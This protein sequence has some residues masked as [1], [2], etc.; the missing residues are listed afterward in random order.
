MCNEERPDDAWWRCT[1]CGCDR[2]GYRDHCNICNLRKPSH[3]A[4]RPIENHSWYCLKCKKL[5]HPAHPFCTTCR[6][7]RPDS[8]WWMCSKCER[9]IEGIYHI[10]KGCKVLKT[11]SIE[12]HR[13]EPALN[14][15]QKE[16]DVSEDYDSPSSTIAPQAPNEA[17]QK[18]DVTV[19][20]DYDSHS[21]SIAVPAVRLDEH[22]AWKCPGGCQMYFH[23]MN[24]YCHMC[25]EEPAQCFCLNTHT[26]RQN[27]VEPRRVY[28]NDIRLSGDV[29]NTNG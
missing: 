29:V 22:F 5:I 21:S 4:V 8:A 14:D 18:E 19:I 28:Y 6:R 2:G 3:K 15:L 27:N 23:A 24:P 25:N 13:R 16:E 11:A 10:C 26:R 20:E 17:Q 7:P 9:F 12:P 1:N